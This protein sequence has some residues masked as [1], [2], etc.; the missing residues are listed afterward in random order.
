[1]QSIKNHWTLHLAKKLLLESFNLF[2]V[3]FFRD[4]FKRRWSRHSPT[5]IDDVQILVYISLH[6]HEVVQSLGSTSPLLN[7]VGPFLR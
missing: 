5:T 3:R 2:R 1:M 6:G 7:V 4:S